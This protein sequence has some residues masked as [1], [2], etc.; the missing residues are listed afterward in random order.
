MRLRRRYLLAAVPGLGL[1]AATF[2]MIA[3]SVAP[4]ISAYN[5]P[6][7]YGVAKHYWMPSTATVSPG[8][9]VK[10]VNP[11]TATYHGL[12]FTG[13]SAGVAPSCTGIPQAATG[14]SGALG[15]WEGECTFSKSGTYTFICTVHPTEMTGTI[16]VPGTA[17]AKTTPASGENQTEAMLNGSI[18]PE[19]N[20]I[21]YHFEYGTASVSEHTTAAASL[22]ATD[23]A[24]HSVSA[25]L[26]GLLPK[27]TYHF[28]LVV[29]YGAGKTTV[30]TSEQTFTTPAPAAPTAITTGA[31][32]KGQHEAT[33]EGTVD[34]NGANATEYFFEYGTT[35]GYGE[36]TTPV[37]GLPADNAKHPAST[38]VPK[39]QSGTTYHFRLVAK[40][41][42]GGPID[43]ADRTFKT[44][45]PPPPEETPPPPTA[46]TTTTTP[47]P[48]P[49]TTL[50]EPPPVPVIEG[51][52][53]L[54]STQRGTSVRGSLDVS[55]SGAGGR[56]EVDLLA[57]TAS[58][59][60]ARRSGST[61]VGRLVRASVSAGKVS[62]SVSL[63]ARGKSA[64]RRHHR[65]A[66]TVK[67]TLTPR[68]GE[69]ATI[70]RSV[71]VRA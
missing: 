43:G 38:M 55:Q 26:T 69:A 6:G 9:A 34:P 16:T 3:S 47:P 21:E 5:E 8:G 12:E 41:D 13:G 44:T 52:P 27:T 1:I 14:P 59:A 53:S 32:V 70:M 4:S 54:R 10:F 37:T 61:R 22:G 57:K 42:A 68:R 67:I 25:S 50:A 28:Q 24:S 20:T 15:R 18:E 66:L 36:K 29:T 19:G 30:P 63:T 11:Y 23:F 7:V 71:V 60:K 51:P 49:T 40:N 39:L 17:K 46:T 33:L 35:E 45:S 31:T 2:P 56:L 64:L 48:P 58:L 62:F 65:L